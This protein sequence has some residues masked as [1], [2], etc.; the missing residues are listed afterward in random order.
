[1]SNSEIMR[2]MR[3]LSV[4]AADALW[5]IRKNKK[6]D[7]NPEDICNDIQQLQMAVALAFTTLQNPPILKRMYAYCMDAARALKTGASKR[8][9]IDINQDIH[10]LRPEVDRLLAQ[11][12]AN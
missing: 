1:M 2:R 12:E 5:A 3:N 9:M 8:A 11:L 6:P 7:R 4:E 10:R